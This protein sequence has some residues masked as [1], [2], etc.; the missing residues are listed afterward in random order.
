MSHEMPGR[1][2]LLSHDTLHRYAYL[3]QYKI[4]IESPCDFVGK[5]LNMVYFPLSSYMHTLIHFRARIHQTMRESFAE[6][7][8]NVASHL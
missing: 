8:P 7:Q 4:A 6:H 5:T 1:I 2:R 3:S